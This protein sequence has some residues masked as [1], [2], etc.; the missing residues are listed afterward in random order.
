MSLE[1]TWSYPPAQSRVSKGKICRTFACLPAGLL[2]IFKEG[3][4]TTSLDNLS[5][6]LT[7]LNVKKTYVS[8]SGISLFK[9]MLVASCPFIRYQ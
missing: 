3:N 1:I 8:L 9:F 5:Q 6:F 2:N 4:A 7:N